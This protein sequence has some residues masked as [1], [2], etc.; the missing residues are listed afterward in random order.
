MNFPVYIDNHATT[1][2]DKRVV[3]AMIPYFTEHFGNPS[4]KTHT[5][6]IMADSVVKKSREKIAES[7]NAKPNEIIFTSGATESINLAIKGIAESYK[8]KGNHIIT[9]A[10][11]HSAVLDSLKYL[12]QKGYEVTYLPVD[13][14]GF[15]DIMEL[16]ESIGKQTILVTIMTANNEIG[17]IQNLKKIGNICK[18]QNIIFHTDAAQGI[19]KMHFNV[20]EMNINLASFTA[21]KIYGPK[22]IGALFIDNTKP[23]IK[24]TPQMHGG[25]HESGFRSGTL[26]VPLIAGFAKAMELCV[27]NLDK[28]IVHYKFLRNKLYSGIINTISGVY[29]NGSLNDRLPN[30]LNISFDGINGDTLIANLKKIALSSGSACSSDTLK[31][32]H[33]LKAIGVSDSL[34]KATL[35]IGIGRFTTEEEID[36]CIDYICSTVNQL[37]EKNAVLN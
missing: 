4:S 15:I 13:K 2:I 31:T 25:G 19:G 32:S 30:N 22:G 26:N 29:I 16:S 14:N 11:E 8:G 21:H 23:K 12:Q 5:F 18:E 10:I 33:V 3:E 20:K 17:T 35:R 28:E 1:P 36:F 27:E 6:G 34:A 24:I 7:I 9:S 37:K